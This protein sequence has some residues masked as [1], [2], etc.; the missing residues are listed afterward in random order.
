MNERFETSLSH[1]QLNKVTHMT[2]YINLYSLGFLNL[3]IIF[4]SGSCK[5]EVMRTVAVF[6]RNVNEFQ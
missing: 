1:L 6:S 4:E 5:G 3:N 2:F